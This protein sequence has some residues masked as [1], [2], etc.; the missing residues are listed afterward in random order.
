M[1][2]ASNPLSVHEAIKLRCAVRSFHPDAVSEAAVRS[3]LA[4]AVR[5]PTA[6]H[7]EPWAF[8][9][10][11]DRVR[12]RRLSDRVKA[13]WEETPPHAERHVLAVVPEAG[14]FLEALSR[15]D[16]NVF[17]DAGT[18]ILI[19]ARPLSQFVTADCWLAAENLMLAACGLGLGTCMVGSAIEALNIPD[20]K[21]ELAIPTDVMVIAPIIVGV[22]SGLAAPTSRSPPEILT[23]VH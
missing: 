9:I 16:F 4:A 17:Y 19:C 12:L 2:E 18:L 11:Q 10:V 5:A 23:W 7:R 1:R 8:V 22:P 13:R 20:V 15:P 14:G 21:S 6:M 3:L